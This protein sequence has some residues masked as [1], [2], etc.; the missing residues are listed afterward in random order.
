MMSDVHD[1]LTSLAAH[2]KELPPGLTEE[3]KDAVN[4]LVSCACVVCLAFQPCTMQS[5]QQLQQ[6]TLCVCPLK[7]F[8]RSPLFACFAIQATEEISAFICPAL[9]DEPG[10]AV[11]PCMRRSF[12]QCLVL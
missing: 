6:F 2:G 3:M 7:S 4:R 10:H 1:A 12:A 11:L 5:S 9:V 8:T